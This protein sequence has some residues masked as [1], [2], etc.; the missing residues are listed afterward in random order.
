MRGTSRDSNLSWIAPWLLVIL[1]IFLA[2]MLT[3][4]PEEVFKSLTFNKG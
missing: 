2:A 1:A 3:L 4:G